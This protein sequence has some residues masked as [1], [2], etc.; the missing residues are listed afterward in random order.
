MGVFCKILAQLGRPKL[1]IAL[2]LVGALGWYSPGGAS[3]A[4]I[5]IACFALWHALYGQ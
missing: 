2:V 1:V 5:A 4:F 3:G